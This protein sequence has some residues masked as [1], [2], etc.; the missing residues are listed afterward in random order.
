M[1]L[2]DESKTEEKQVVRQINMPVR[3]KPKYK[4]KA[5]AAK[6]CFNKGTKGKGSVRVDPMKDTST[7]KARESSI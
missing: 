5:S 6:Y 7:R 3:A 1:I 2:L 4:R